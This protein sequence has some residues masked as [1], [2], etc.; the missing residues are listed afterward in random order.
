MT[1]TVR[2]FF[3]AITVFAAVGKELSSAKLCIAALEGKKSKSFIKKLNS[4][5]LF[6]SLEGHQKLS[7]DNHFLY[8]LC[9]LID[10]GLWDT[11]KYRIT[12]FDLDRKLQALLLTGRA[13]YTRFFYKQLVYKQLDF[14][15][16]L[17]NSSAGRFLA[18]LQISNW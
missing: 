6:W 8:H 18:N 3:G 9:E 16:W 13:K 2:C 5:V 12:L 7:F 17:S 15:K 11:N 1:V 14:I 10:F 4:M